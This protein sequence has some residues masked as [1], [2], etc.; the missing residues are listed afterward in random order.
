MV[1]D[2]GTVKEVCGTLQFNNVSITQISSSF[3]SKSVRFSCG[4]RFAF[5]ICK[6]LHFMDKG[7]FTLLTLLAC[8]DASS[9]LVSYSGKSGRPLC[10][11][12]SDGGLFKRFQLAWT[13]YR[14][15]K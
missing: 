15:L 2:M 9:G 10:H 5:K 7:A 13:I 12:V 14:V 8:N 6:C 3:I 1:H 11:F 4:Q